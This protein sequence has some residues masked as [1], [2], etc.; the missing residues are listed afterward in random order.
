MYSIRYLGQEPRRYAGR[1]WRT[2]LVVTDPDGSLVLE[3][4]A[5]GVA[6]RFQI[7]PDYLPAEQPPPGPAPWT[8][9]ASRKAAR[10]LA[11]DRA[12]AD[13]EAAKLERKAASKPQDAPKASRATAEP[14]DAPEA[15]SEPDGG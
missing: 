8:L 12:A 5:A 4:H 11:K 2:G 10:G 9:Q 14:D 7:A 6:G 13:R 15:V 3:L 1:A